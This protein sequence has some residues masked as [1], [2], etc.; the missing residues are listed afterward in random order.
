M[1]ATIYTNKN[2]PVQVSCFYD[3]IIYYNNLSIG[4]GYPCFSPYVI[5][6]QDVDVDTSNT[7]NTNII[8]VTTYL[9]HLRVWLKEDDEVDNKTIILYKTTFHNDINDNALIFLSYS[10]QQ[11]TSNKIE[12]NGDLYDRYVDLYIPS[13]VDIDDC[14]WSVHNIESNVYIIKDVY[15][16]EYE[17][18]TGI[19]Q[20][21]LTPDLTI[22]FD[23]P[24]ENMIRLKSDV[25]ERGLKVNIS[26]PNKLSKYNKGYACYTIYQYKMDGYVD[27]STTITGT[28]ERILAHKEQYL[29]KL[30]DVLSNYRNKNRDE[31]SF[32]I[33][34]NV[35][36]P[37]ISYVV[38]EASAVLWKDDNTSL[39]DRH[40]GVTYNDVIYVTRNPL[41]LSN[42][43]PMQNGF[44]D[45]EWDDA[46]TIY[47]GNAD[48][49]KMNNKY[50][51][52]PGPSTLKVYNNLNN[53]DNTGYNQQSS[54]N[55]STKGYTLFKV[56][57]NIEQSVSTPTSIITPYY[58]VICTVGTAALESIDN[59]TDT[60]NNE[61]W[62]SQK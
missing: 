49:F 41:S 18:L 28:S 32:N 11:I 1:A 10:F 52:V 27:S 56:S 59:Q 38:V 58:D 39:E 22:M 36:D 17:D 15:I 51:H 20:G 4:D 47:S 31:L 7:P 19:L 45:I 35:I 40:T 13:Q 46:F 6:P 62:T 43:I 29:I 57:S 14:I 9:T 24:N 12:I 33:Y 34:I 30:D 23:D 54:S 8:T 44:Y 61:L 5:I 42:K 37:S 3:R 25:I 48:A 50:S 26:S 55:A 60:T 21:T 16:P 2:T 53:T